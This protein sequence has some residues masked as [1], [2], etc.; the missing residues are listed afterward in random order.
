MTDETIHTLIHEAGGQFLGFQDGLTPADRSVMFREP[1]TG[2]SCSIYV[3]AITSVEDFRLAL[4]AKRELF[5]LAKTA[6]ML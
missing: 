3:R 1:T 4:K 5:A 2:S 6:Q